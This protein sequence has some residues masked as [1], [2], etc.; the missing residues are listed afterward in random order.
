MS[1]R[2]HQMLEKIS[3]SFQGSF[4]PGQCGRAS[5]NTMVSPQFRR[6]SFFDLP[7]TESSARKQWCFM[8]CKNPPPPRFSANELA[9]WRSK[10]S[11][12]AVSKLGQ[13]ID[14]DLERFLAK[15]MN[16]TTVELEAGHRSEE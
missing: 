16:A 9:A 10:P 13:T 7:P 15:R 4:L 3:L 12:Y 5:S 2:G 1:R 14:P 11:W 8:P 6:R